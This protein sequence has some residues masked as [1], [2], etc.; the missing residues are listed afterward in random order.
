[1]GSTHRLSHRDHAILR[2]VAAGTAQL[3]GGCEPDLF[4]DGRCCSDQ[5]AA[6]RLVHAGL[7][8][9]SRTGAH[10]QRVPAVLTPAAHELLL[11]G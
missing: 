1:M 4:L 10:H 2:A 8:A 7:I 6:H 3:S 5:L 9:P 11:A